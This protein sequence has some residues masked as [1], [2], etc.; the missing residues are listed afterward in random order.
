MQTFFGLQDEKSNAA[1]AS[2]HW[3]DTEYGASFGR[4]SPELDA[5]DSWEMFF[6]YLTVKK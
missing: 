5:L 4:I 2:S 6:V 1:Q 3:V